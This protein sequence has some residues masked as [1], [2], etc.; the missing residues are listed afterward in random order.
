[1]VK[2]CST[3]QEKIE[4]LDLYHY[5][6]ARQHDVRHKISYHNFGSLI[7]GHLPASTLCR[8]LKEEDKLRAGAKAL[9]DGA[10]YIVNRKLVVLEQV[11]CRWLEDQRKQ[12]TPVNG[13]M[14]KKAAAVTYIIL[15]ECHAPHIDRPFTMPSFS[16]SWFD[17]FKKRYR[18]TYC[19]LH[20]EAGS[21]DLEAIEPELVEIRDFASLFHPKDILNCDET[22][23]YL[24]ELDDKS[25]TTDSVSGCKPNRSSRVSLLLC[26]NADGSSLALAETIDAFKPWVLGT[27]CFN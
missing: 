5:L 9:P 16:A 25:Y 4:Y 24:K 6:K 22:G 17:A 1:M 2:V 14:I 8:M 11:V 20:G 10:H 15:E 23:F 19:Q 7:G 13:K 27:I 12:N 18:I 3:L 21:V 26:M